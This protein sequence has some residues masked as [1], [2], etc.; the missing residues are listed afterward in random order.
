[1]DYPDDSRTAIESSSNESTGS[2]YI[3][4]TDKYMSK[5]EDSPGGTRPDVVKIHNPEDIRTKGC[6]PRK[7][8]RRSKNLTK[9]KESANIVTSMDIMIIELVQQEKRMKD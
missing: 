3:Q 6:G 4:H 7:K 8:R 5:E 9:K 1:M 2:K